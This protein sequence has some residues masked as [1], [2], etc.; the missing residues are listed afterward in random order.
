MPFRAAQANISDENGN[1]LMVTN[2]YWIADIRSYV[3][4]R[5][6]TK[7]IKDV[8]YPG[9]FDVLYNFDDEN[10]LSINLTQ[11]RI[12]G[13]IRYLNNNPDFNLIL[14]GNTS[15]ERSDDYN[16]ILGQR[17]AND[18]ADRVVQGGIP[19]ERLCTD[20]KGE[21]NPKI[22]P[23]DTETKRGQNRRVSIINEPA[24]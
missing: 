17:R 23:D 15:T 1:L 11:A 4:N 18:I 20:S 13:Y 5:G 3:A 16:F 6:R 9:R 14:E 8:L 22:S 12:N 2:G 10:S 24:R 7:D 21:K 19:S